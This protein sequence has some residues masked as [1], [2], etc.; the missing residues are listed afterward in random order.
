LFGGR[1]P[2]PPGNDHSYFTL[3]AVRP[4]VTVPT[5]LHERVVVLP[6]VAMMATVG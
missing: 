4:V 2:G 5:I 1:S 3:S 6:V